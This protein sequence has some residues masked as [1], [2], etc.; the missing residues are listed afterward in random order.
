LSGDKSAK[1]KDLRAYFGEDTPM[2]FGCSPHEKQD[3]IEKL[4]Q[5]GEEVMMIGDGLNDAGAL[6]Q[7]NIG[8]AISEDINNFTPASDVIMESKSFEK[9]AILIDYIGYAKKIVI[10]SFILSLMYNVVGLSIAVQGQMSPFIAA[11]LMPASSIS[12]ILFTTGSARIVA[13][14]KALRTSSI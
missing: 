6:M 2:H 3:Y 12:I 1:A 7:S 13:R 5:N 4:R 14:I 10:A 9:M 8:W 11:I